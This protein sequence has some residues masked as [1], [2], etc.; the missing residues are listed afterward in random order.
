MDINRAKEI[1]R[2]LADGVDPTTG[3]VLP[4]ESVYNSPEVIRA[5]FTLL[6]QVNAETAGGPLRNTGKPWTNVEDDKLRDEYL[7][8]LKISDIAKEHGRTY[9]IGRQ[10]EAQKLAVSNSKG[11]NQYTEK[12]VGAQN[13]HQPK[14]KTAEAIAKEHGIGRE[15]VKRAEKFSKGVDAAGRLFLDKII[16][17]QT[18]GKVLPM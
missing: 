11:A 9:L 18:S 3:E 5:L 4:A 13:G 8:N 2:T 12:E 10:Y 6:E 14:M 17:I 7:S 16:F 15:S 1:I